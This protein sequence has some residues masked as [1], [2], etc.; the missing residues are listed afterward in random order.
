MIIMSLNFSEVP[1]SNAAMVE[2]LK[3]ERCI[4]SIEVVQAMS[5]VDRSNYCPNKCYENSPVSIGHGQSISSP[6]IH[7]IALEL[8]LPRLKV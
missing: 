2:Q 7:G 6:S 1:V 5:K 3:K 4:E 8:L